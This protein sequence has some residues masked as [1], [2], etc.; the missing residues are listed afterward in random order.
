[1]LR[2]LKLV[3]RVDFKSYLKIQLFFSPLGSL[4]YMRGSFF[5]RESSLSALL[6]YR[7]CHLDGY[8]L[9]FIACQCE[10]W[11]KPL[12]I[13]IIGLCVLLS[14]AV[15]LVLHFKWLFQGIVIWKR[16]K[17]HTS[18]KTVPNWTAGKVLPPQWCLPIAEL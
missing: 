17:S 16:E 2:K 6:L 11:T 9:P 14:H 5:L 1:M 15:C 13:I 12:T 3:Q 8:S 18:V 7:S 10:V 4:E